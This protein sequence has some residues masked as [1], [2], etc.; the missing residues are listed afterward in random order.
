MYAFLGKGISFRVHAER[1]NDDTYPDT[2]AAIV[3]LDLEL[4]KLGQQFDSHLP[5]VAGTDV[6]CWC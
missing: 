2:R 1:E 3:L 5:T 4:I 6:L